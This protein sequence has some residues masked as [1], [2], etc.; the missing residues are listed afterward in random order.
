M[1]FL[2]LEVGVLVFEPWL[3]LVSTS[4]GDPL[5]IPSVGDI[6]ILFTLLIFAQLS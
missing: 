3:G 2:L 4:M 6:Y 1:P 5:G